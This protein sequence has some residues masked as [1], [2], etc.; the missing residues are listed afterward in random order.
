MNLGDVMNELYESFNRYFEIV[1][2]DTPQLRE[3]VYKIRY[4]VLCVEQR[5]PGFEPSQYPDEQE[6]DDN[7][8]HSTHALLKFRSTNEFIGTVRLILF[9]PEQPQKLFPVELNTQ[10]DLN[11]C[12]VDK[13]PRQ[14][15]AEVSRFVVINRFNRRKENRRREERQPSTDGTV[16]ENRREGAGQSDD[17]TV[18]EQRRV[19]TDRRSGLTIALVLMAGVMRMSIQHNIRN[20]LSMMDT[21]LNRL[22]SFDGLAFIPIGPPINYHGMRRPYFVKVDDVLNRMRRDHHDAWR[23]L[24]ADGKYGL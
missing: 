23:V 4:Q 15:T 19:I 20:W 16:T 13:L 14:Q 5:I 8:I 10:L 3:Q 21:P 6:R 24:T 11:L 9:N 18:T 17:G 12:D 7:D 2:A 22:L 1:I